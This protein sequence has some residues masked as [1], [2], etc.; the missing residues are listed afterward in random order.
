[1]NGIPRINAAVSAAPGEGWGATFQTEL[2]NSMV[3]PVLKSAVVPIRTGCRRLWEAW[4]RA[5]RT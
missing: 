3:R 5:V 2:S 1:M 4:P